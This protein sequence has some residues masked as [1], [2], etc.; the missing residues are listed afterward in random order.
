MNEQRTAGPGDIP[1]ARMHKPG[2][3]LSDLVRGA[4]FVQAKL[5][6]GWEILPDSENRL[7]PEWI[8]PIAVAD[9]PRP[10]P[11]EPEPPAPKKRGRPKKQA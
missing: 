11:V 4:Y 7:L 8:K 6:G 2:T 10:V 9:T 1:R 5:A 3:Q